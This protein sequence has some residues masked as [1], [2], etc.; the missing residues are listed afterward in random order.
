MFARATNAA[1]PIA[2]APSATRTTASAS[3]CS[4]YDIRPRATLQ[5]KIASA[6]ARNAIAVVA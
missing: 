2:F 4:A 3:G 6:S 1:G 5:P